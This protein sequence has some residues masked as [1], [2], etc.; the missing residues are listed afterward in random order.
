[1]AILL[2]G[3]SPVWAA[4]CAGSIKNFPVL[5]GVAA[6]GL[7]EI[8]AW[9]KSVPTP[10][11]V[12]IDTFGRV[13]PARDKS[14]S[15]Y[16]SDYRAR[17]LLQRLA[18]ELGIAILAIH[19][20]RKLDSDDPLDTVSGTTGTSGAADSI[21]VINRDGQGTTLHGRGRDLDDIEVAISFDK[22]TGRW[23]VMGNAQEVRRSESRSSILDVL[24]K[25]AEKSLTPAEIAI[26]TGMESNAVHAQLHRMMRSGEVLSSKRGHYAH[27]SRASTPLSPQEP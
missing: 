16:D 22:T 7:D 13:R 20:Q 19:H 5:S 17:S 10:R 12:V 11:L 24:L 25:T 21:L 9:V 6:G 18:T 8:R 4:S 3:W 23:T 26:L 14:E 1:L 2:S 27:P 15:T